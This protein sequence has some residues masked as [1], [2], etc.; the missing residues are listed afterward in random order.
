MCCVQC[1]G[2]FHPSCVAKKKSVVQLE[3]NRI[4]CSKEC[5][6]LKMENEINV[7]EMIKQLDKLSKD[8]RTKDEV[9]LGMEEENDG[10]VSRLCEEISR[11]K[12]EMGERVAFISKLERRSSDFEEEVQNIEQNYISEIDEQK[13]KISSLNNNILKLVQENNM[14]REECTDMR[15][16]LDEVREEIAACSELRNSML[17]SIEALTIETNTYM[18]EL[19]HLKY[20][21]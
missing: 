7:G 14:L 2:I 6:R 18:G 9:I 8:V 1:L 21:N 17:T 4:V 19:K 16:R 15:L 12:T 13:T 11:L 3:S 5:E 20:E 10:R